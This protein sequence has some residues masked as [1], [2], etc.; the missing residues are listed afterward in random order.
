M[1]KE[2]LVDPRTARNTKIPRRKG[3]CFRLATNCGN[4]RKA[5]FM[6]EIFQLSFFF[7][8]LAILNPT[9]A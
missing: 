8:V 6:R 9:H 4:V 2:G 3:C 7:F 1:V 5:I